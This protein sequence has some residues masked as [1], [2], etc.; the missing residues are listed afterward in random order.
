MTADKTNTARTWQFN[1]KQSK[2]L[3]CDQQ[4]DDEVPI[5]D[6]GAEHWIYC[7]KEG[8]ENFTRLWLPKLTQ[9]E[10]E[11]QPPFADIDCTAKRI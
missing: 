8:S 10:V 5:T 2:N 6:K 9:K 7:M 1:N 4:L 3:V 11:R